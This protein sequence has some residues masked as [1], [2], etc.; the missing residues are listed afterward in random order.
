MRLLD[1]RSLPTRRNCPPQVIASNPHGE[2]WLIRVSEW[3]GERAVLMRPIL[4]GSLN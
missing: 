4:I 2:I 3:I 1:L